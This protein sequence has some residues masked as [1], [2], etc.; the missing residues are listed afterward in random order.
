MN[1][2]TGLV[3][4]VIIFGICLLVIYNLIMKDNI[5]TNEEHMINILPDEFPSWNRNK[6]KFYMNETLKNVLKDNYINQSDEWNLYFPCGYDN[7]S[8]EIKDMP[9]K[10][11]A[12]YFIINNADN[13]TAKEWLWQYVVKHHGFEKAKTM[14]PVT[15]V[16]S[17]PIDVNELKSNYKDD[18]LYI[19]KKNVQRQEGLK[20]TNK[21]SE[22][23]DGKK[24]GYIIAQELLQNPYTIDG[25]K[26]NM[27]FYVLVVCKDNDTNVY[28]HNNGFMYYTRDKFVK[29]SVEE[30][31]NITT[32]YIDRQVYI[33]NPLTHKD[34]R[35]Y[36]DNI[37][38][39]NKTEKNIREQGLKISDV[40][41]GKIYQLIK[42]VYT[43]FLGR[44]CGGDKLKNNVT[45]QLF[46]IDIAVDENINPKIMEINKGPDMGAK[47]KRD[48][49]V[50]HGVIADMMN[51]I[52]AIKT[53]HDNGF[54]NIIEFENG[55]L[56]H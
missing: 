37:R 9:E 28:V 31:P 11:G 52:G 13:M 18:N 32:G 26:T 53:S 48:S 17:N 40:Y 12:K 8:K 29:G 5:H 20:I 43:S 39:L 6:C 51:I 23:M 16:L 19:M 24:N 2:N 15:Y 30:G 4:L 55:T 49:D 33:D 34:L 21:L 41:F 45:F 38:S 22:L 1:I 25:R 50:K 14:M 54:I 3:M 10:D 47:D 7:I 56:K 46:G 27:R 42:E 36:L 35:V 44:I